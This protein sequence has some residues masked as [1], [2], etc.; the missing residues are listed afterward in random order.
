MSQSTTTFTGAQSVAGKPIQV[1]TPAKSKDE[2]GIKW[3]DKI[4]GGEIEFNRYGIYSIAL[5]LIGI[6]AGVAVG[7]GAMSSA[8]TIAI[9][10]IP[11]MASLVM[12]LGVAPMRLLIWT[13]LITCLIDIIMIVAMIASWGEPISTLF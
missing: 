11:T 8:L 6:L 1:T 7:L 9:L 10:I 12:I 5:L 2:L 4:I 3:L 13:V